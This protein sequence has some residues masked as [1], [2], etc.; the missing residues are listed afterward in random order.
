M[1][2][3]R[4]ILL[5]SVLVFAQTAF[6]EISVNFR[7]MAMSEFV[8]FVSEFTG[9]NFVYDKNDLKGQVSIESSSEINA[10]DIME[11][12]ASTLRA[13]GLDLINRG[14]Y[15][16]IVKQNDLTEVPDSYGTGDDNALVTTVISAKN[17]D[18]KMLAGVV[19]KLKS[20]A[21]YV[22]VLKGLNAIVM[23]DRVER[24]T[25]IKKIIDKLEDRADIYSLKVI[26]IEHASAK[27]VEETL[28]KI[29][30][31]MEKK[32]LL[33]VEPVVVADEYA[34]LLVVACSEG[35]FE[36]LSY[37]ISQIDSPSPGSHNAPKVFYLNNANAEDVEKVLE[38]L[39]GVENT[40]KSKK[41]VT[42]KS[43]VASDKAT[44]SIIVFGDPDLYSKVEKLIEKL[45]KPREQ[46]YVEAL[47]LETTLESGNKFG[48]EWMAGGG[49]KSSAGTIGY[50]NDNGS[51]VNFQSPVLDGK[52]P[53]YAALAGGF[54]LGIL[55]NIISYEGVSFP[56]LGILANFVK[57]ANGIN[58][59]SNPQILTLDN[60]EAEVFVGENR[61]FLT[62]TKFDSNNNPIQSYDYRDVGVKLKIVPQIS[63]ND[64]VTLKIEQ[65]VKK[66]SSST[67][68][69]T[70]PVTLTRSTKT[71]VKL[72]DGSIMVISGLLKD[73][74]E[75]YNTA[76]PGLSRIPI[77]GWLFKTKAG[78]YEKTNM[79]V[80]ISTFIIRTQEDAQ[81]MTEKKKQ[82]SVDFKNEIDSKI[83]KEFK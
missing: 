17:F 57:S 53:N 66:V 42:T 80:F 9:K 58:I 5:I 7:D 61:P 62:S 11:I 4:F 28:K 27:G 48:V 44:N 79:M 69:A 43:T 67:V 64:S 25:M 20:R 33:S 81:K 34:N 18:S 68:D 74:S 77:L 45:D 46:V 52:A 39:T 47:I 10:D 22:D 29:Y 82:E 31:D 50:L 54:N 72:K 26:K 8:S 75:K 32:M 40:D 78:S 14:T 65:E 76:V 23:R 83:Q 51:L 71:K 16:E 2:T 6:A 70:A 19:L 15:T 37:V 30:A 35:D 56:T 73:D 63:S 41:A 13:N 1:K 12:F 60:E 59:L 49:S 55:G 38:K 3:I 36:K 21:G 24:I